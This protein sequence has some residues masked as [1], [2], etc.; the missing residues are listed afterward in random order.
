MSEKEIMNEEQTTSQEQDVK[1]GD[2]DASQAEA[3]NPKD[4]ITSS[5]E[6]K[7]E[8]EVKE[9]KDKYLRLYSEFENYRRRTAKERLDLITTA[10]ED[11]IRE[12][13]PI[14]DDFERAFKANEKEEDAT[15]VREGNQLVFYKLIKTLENK[16]VK[17]MDDLIGNPFNA[18]TQEAITQIPAPNDELKGKVIDVVEKGYTLGDK[19]IRYAKVVTG[20]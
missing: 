20:A 11:L 8:I 3:I 1:Q 7:L 9:L 6:E 12:I 17:V 4:T 2:L 16:G 13:L 14:I 10:S 5:V 18:D 19:V 15:K